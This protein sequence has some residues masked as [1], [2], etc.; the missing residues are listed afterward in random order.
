MRS[1]EVFSARLVQCQTG[2]ECL[3][4]VPENHAGI[5]YLEEV[6]IITKEVKVLSH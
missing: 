6:S 5:S 2:T 1:S 4:T 3:V